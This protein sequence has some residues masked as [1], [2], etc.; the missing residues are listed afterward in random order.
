M[1]IYEICE[2]ILSIIL[3]IVLA[4]VTFLPLICITKDYLDI[5]KEDK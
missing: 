3:V 2:I 5:F 1:D 4:I